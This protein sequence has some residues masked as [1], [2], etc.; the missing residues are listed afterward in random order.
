MMSGTQWDH[1]PHCPNAQCGKRLH[2]VTP[3]RPGD[4]RG[5]VIGPTRDGCCPHCETPLFAP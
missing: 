4:P 1:F 3:R 5:P 2:T